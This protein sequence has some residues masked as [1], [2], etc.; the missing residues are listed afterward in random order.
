MGAGAVLPSKGIRRGHSKI[1]QGE[2]DPCEGR[3]ALTDPV[4]PDVPYVAGGALWTATTIGRVQGSVARGSRIEDD[5]LAA[6]VD[7]IL[8]ATVR[9]RPVVAVAAADAVGPPVAGDDVVVT[10]FA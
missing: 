5:D 10:G 4:R 9:P 3:S 6:R 2:A 8:A 7:Q 1:A